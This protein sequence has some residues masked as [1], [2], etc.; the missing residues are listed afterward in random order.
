VK[1]VGR[2]KVQLAP[3]VLEGWGADVLDRIKRLDPRALEAEA[4]REFER[5]VREYPDVPH[6]DKIRQPGTLGTVAAGYLHEL[7]DLAVGRPAPEIEGV[8]LD[9]RRFRL[10]EYRGSVVVLDF[11][12]HFYCGTCRQMYPRERAL[13]KKLEGRPFALVTVDVDDDREGLKAAWKAEGNAWRCVWDGAWDGPIN[14][15]WNIQ[16]YPS[17]YVLD[18][19]GVIRY[20]ATRDPGGELDRVVADLLA[21]LAASKK[22]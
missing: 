19:N 14:T 8:D 17:I 9:G 13:V 16:V 22:K 20:K 15:A 4:E 7:R 5:L 12:S 10:S 6:N 18:H 11:G 3:V 21:D 2:F 1:R